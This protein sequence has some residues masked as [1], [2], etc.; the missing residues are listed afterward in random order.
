MMWKLKCNP[1]IAVWFTGQDYFNIIKIE[2]NWIWLPTSVWDDFKI[3]SKG[4]KQMFLQRYFPSSSK[5]D[6]LKPALCKLCHPVLPLR[7]PLLC[8]CPWSKAELAFSPSDQFSGL[9]ARALRRINCFISLCL[10]SRCLY[11]FFLGGGGHTC[12][13]WRFP[14]QGW[15][16]SCSH[17]LTPQPQQHRIQAMSVTYTTAH[18][19]ASSLTY[20]ARPGIK[21]ASS[22]MLVRLVN[23]WAT[24][25][26]PCLY[27]VFGWSCSMRK[28]WVGV[29]TPTTAE[30]HA[31]AQATPD[32]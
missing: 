2:F 26:T 1:S 15:N 7:G 23:L 4:V 6:K 8:G 29:R 19:N 30:T 14:G 22:W 21:P 28:F 18:S 3:W 20:W 31:T 9:N 17:W 27:S 16:W 5:S 32:P 25:G 11:C 13:M 12:G 24:V 10:Y